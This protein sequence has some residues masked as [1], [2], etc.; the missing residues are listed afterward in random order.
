MDY[1]SI[2]QAPPIAFHS[3]GDPINPPVEPMKDPIIV[4]PSSQNILGKK[5]CNQYANEFYKKHH[6]QDKSHNFVLQKSLPSVD[7]PMHDVLE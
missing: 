2:N 4:P 6:A 3:L 1:T 7:K 5:K